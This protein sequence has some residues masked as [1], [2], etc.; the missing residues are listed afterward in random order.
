MSAIIERLKGL[1]DAG[2][3]SAMLRFGLGQAQLAAG[4]VA[5]AVSHLRAAVDQDPGYSAA[6]KLLGQALT[7]LDDV[8]A[9]MEAYESGI[10]AAGERGDKQAAK[11]MQVFLKRLRKRSDEVNGG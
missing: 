11:E 3:D 5:E 10:T 6:W 7:R 2:Q 1:L 4:D 9:A 8:P